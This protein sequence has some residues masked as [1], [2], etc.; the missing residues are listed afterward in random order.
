MQNATGEWIAAPYVSG[1]IVVNIGDL[2]AKASGGRFVATLH[3]MRA[4]ALGVGR[5]DEGM[6]RFSVPFFFEPGEACVVRSVNGGGGEGVVYGEHV[7]R[8][9]RAWVEFCDE[10]PVAVV[11]G[12]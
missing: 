4:R 10:P 3:R 6:G 5:K 2:I 12:L 8:K 11:D 9:M 7:R 1:S